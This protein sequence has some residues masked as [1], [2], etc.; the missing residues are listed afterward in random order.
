MAKKAA[1]KKSTAPKKPAAR[2][3]NARAG[4][5]KKTAKKSRLLTAFKTL[6]FLILLVTAATAAFLAW[7]WLSYNADIPAQTNPIGTNALWARHAWVGEKHS[8]K[9]YDAFCAD[10]RLNRIGDI[11]S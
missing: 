1:P 8:R 10:V 9:D 6:F 4:K 2:G 5:K 7:C 3:G 11:L